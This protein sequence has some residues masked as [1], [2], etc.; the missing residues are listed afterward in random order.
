MWIVVAAWLAAFLVFSSFFMKTIVPLR[1]VAMVSNVV[2][3][4]YALLGLVY[5]V[6]GRVYPILVLHSCLLPL[7]VLRLRQLRTLITAVHEASDD[8]AIHALTPFMT[9]QTRRKGD[10]LFKQGEPADRLYLLQS[11]RI[12]FT[13]LDKHVSPGALFGE[14]GLFAPHGVRTLT[15]VCAEDCRLATISRDKV[16]ELYYQNPKFGFFLIRLIAGYMPGD[17]GGD[18]AAVPAR[19]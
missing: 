9:T 19:T 7:N 3:I 8:E 10:T 4:V 12:G 14:V 6:F 17:R 18:P 2:F 5:G 11:G 16:L 15:A 1:I 13:E